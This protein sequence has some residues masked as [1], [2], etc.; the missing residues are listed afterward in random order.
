MALGQPVIFAIDISLTHT[1]QVFR[2]LGIVV[3]R[4]CL[5][6]GIGKCKVYRLGLRVVGTQTS[7]KV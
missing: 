1:R 2:K 6:I 5:E 4:K 3:F 7:C